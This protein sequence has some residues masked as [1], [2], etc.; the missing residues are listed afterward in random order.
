MLRALQQR[1][2]DAEKKI[3][4]TL[5]TFHIIGEHSYGPGRVW[6]PQQIVLALLEQDRRAVEAEH[7]LFS[8]RSNIIV[9]GGTAKTPIAVPVAGGNFQALWAGEKSPIFDVINGKGLNVGEGARF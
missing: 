1:Q 8:E 9:A 2:H 4:I 5:Q 6:V 3:S 7:Q